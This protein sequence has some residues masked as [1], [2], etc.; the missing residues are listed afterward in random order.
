M[1]QLLLKAST[2]THKHSYMPSWNQHT[3]ATHA[4]HVLFFSDGLG[5]CTIKLWWPT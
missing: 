3:H 2:I 4:E 5:R 1:L